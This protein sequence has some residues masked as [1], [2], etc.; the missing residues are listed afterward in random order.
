VHDWTVHK[1]AEIAPGRR[2][3]PRIIETV[4][5]DLEVLTVSI[6]DAARRMGMGVDYTRELVKAGRLKAIRTG[7]SA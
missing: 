7:A 5:T 4:S 1:A 6:P 2:D 3:A